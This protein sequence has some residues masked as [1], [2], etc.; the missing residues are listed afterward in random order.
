M[1]LFSYL[2][3]HTLSSHA[4]AEAYL[5]GWQGWD[6][7][8]GRRV[9]GSSWRPHEINS[10]ACQFIV[11]IFSKICGPVKLEICG[12]YAKYAAIACSL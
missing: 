12:K 3:W 1:I 4:S 7:E 6:W 9:D 5:T 8:T 11:E 10:Q 2:G